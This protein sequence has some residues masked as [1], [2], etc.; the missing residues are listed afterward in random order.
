VTATGPITRTFTTGA[1]GAYSFS[2]LS[3]GDYTVTA[4]KFGFATGSGTATVTDGGSATLNIDLVAA[5]SSTVSGTVTT[6]GSPVPGA[7]V[8]LIGSPLQ[9]VT[10]G[11]GF[12]SITAPDGSYTLSVTSPLRCSDSVSQPL[13]LNGNVTVNITLPERT[14]AFGYAC[15]TAA[16]SFT[17]GTTLF[18]LT[19]DDQQAPM[20]LPFTIPFYGLNY[21]SISITTNGSA[22]FGTASATQTNVHIPTTGAP[23]AAIFPLWDDLFV[24]GPAGIFTGTTGSAPHRKFIIEWRNV[25]SFFD[26]SQRVTFAAE[27]GEDGSIV[28]RYKDVNGSSFATGT[29]ASIGIENETGTV[30]FEYSFEQGVV[31]NG[32]AIAFRTTRHGVV[33]GRRDRCQ[34]RPARRGR[35]GHVR[36]RRFRSDR[37]G[38]QLPQADSVRLAHPDRDQAQLRHGDAV[39]HARGRGRGSRQRQP[40]HGQGHGHAGIADARGTR[41]RKPRADRDGRQRRRRRHSADA[42]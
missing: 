41:R 24:D 9:T 3:V 31:S 42:Q 2:T 22:A 38:W 6:A 16:G 35:R 37:G 36:P 21:N 20:T 23:N 39:G 19:G 25:R 30:G 1:D 18:P 7:T 17:P 5:A 33:S 12:Y 32:L 11:S 34:R 15:G 14:D 27:L 4:S 28:Y 8:K 29:S 10:N 40:G 13:T 26:S